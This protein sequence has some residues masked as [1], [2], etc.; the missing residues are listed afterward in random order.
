MPQTSP[1]PTKKKVLLLPAVSLGAEHLAMGYLLRRNILTYKA[2][3]NNEGYDLICIHPNHKIKSKTLK[4]QVK[5]R[6]QSDHG[7]GFPLKEKNLDSF[8]FLIVVFL[9]IGY[10][11]RKS[12]HA[13]K[14]GLK[15]IDIYTFPNEFIKRIYKTGQKGMAKVNITKE[16][17]QEIEKYKN[18]KGFELIAKKLKIE[19]PERLG[20]DE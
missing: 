2:P 5:S 8:D 14:E 6:M 17:R 13:T 3:P 1:S 16:L 11:N 4:I 20:A 15:P 7:W 10:Y 18:E 12:K 19:Y 9:N